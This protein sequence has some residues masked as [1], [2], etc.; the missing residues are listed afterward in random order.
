[1]CHAQLLGRY[2]HVFDSDPESGSGAEF[3]HWHWEHLSRKCCAL[4]TRAKAGS[5]V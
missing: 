2:K 4:G 3:Q 1:M 5:G